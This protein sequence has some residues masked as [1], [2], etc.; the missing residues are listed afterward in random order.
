MAECAGAGAAASAALG[1]A[2]AAQTG[3][4]QKRKRVSSTRAR[5]VE[6][7]REAEAVPSGARPK[8]VRSLGVSMTSEEAL[9]QAQA[10]GWTLVPAA[11][12]S[13]YR[14]VSYQSGKP[15][16]YKATVRRAGKNVQL[17]SF[18]TAEEAALCVARSEGRQ[19]AATATAAAERAVEER[20]AVMYRA[21]EQALAALG[22]GKKRCR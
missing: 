5:E 2:D 14:G 10:E 16:P 21:A 22:K 20:A 19:Q 1:A 3:D 6:E 9:Q 15:N 12:T 8:A 7:Q 11:T 13:G 18:A 17:G 4:P